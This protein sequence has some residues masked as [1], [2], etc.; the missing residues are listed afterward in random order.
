MLHTHI[1]DMRSGQQFYSTGNTLRTK[2]LKKSVGVD[3]IMTLIRA[4]ER[5][6]GCRLD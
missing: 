1:P 3:C 4:L 2:Y 5:M 6:R